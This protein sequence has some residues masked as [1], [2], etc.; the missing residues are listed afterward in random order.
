[1]IKKTIKT[2]TSD[3]SETEAET[4]KPKA[5]AEH[6]GLE[7]GNYSSIARRTGFTSQHIMRVL[8]GQNT[9]TLDSAYEIA[10]I[11]KVSLDELYEHIQKQRAQ[12]KRKVRA[13]V[14]NKVGKKAAK[15]K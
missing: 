2:E 1:M 13:A 10:K 9:T 15:K 7:V 4:K 5:T 14:K 11:A 3:S 6:P 8:K 12:H